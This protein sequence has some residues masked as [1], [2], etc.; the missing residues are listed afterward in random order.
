MPRLNLVHPRGAFPKEKQSVKPQFGSRYRSQS[1]QSRYGSRLS[2]WRQCFCSWS[3]CSYRSA[4]RSRPSEQRH[5]FLFWFCRDRDHRSH[6]HDQDRRI[7]I[8][9]KDLPTTVAAMVKA[10]LS[11]LGLMKDPS[12]KE[13]QSQKSPSESQ[14]SSGRDEI[15]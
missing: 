1:C 13:R 14:G 7:S 5:C 10:T 11:E 9:P 12:P 2:E 4:Y 3:R 6:R 8:E 15:S